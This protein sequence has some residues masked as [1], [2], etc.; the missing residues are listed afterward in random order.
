VAV[1]QLG[2]LGVQACSAIMRLR[3]FVVHARSSLTMV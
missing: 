3:S 2:R 1:V